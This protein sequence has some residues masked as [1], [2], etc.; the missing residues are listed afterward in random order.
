MVTGKFCNLC[1]QPTKGQ[2][3]V[4]RRLGSDIH[5][6]LVVCQRCEREARRCAI[7]RIPISPVVS[8]NGLCPTCDTQVPRCAACGQRI[9]GHY[10]RNESNG[11]YYCETCFNHRPHCGVCGGAVGRGGYQL[12]DGRFICAQC[13]DTA[14]Y[15][16]GKAAD[17]YEQVTGIMDQR[18]GMRL[19]MLPSLSLVD[20]NQM[21]ALLEQTEISDTDDPDRVFGLFLRRGRKRTIYVEYGLP[22]ILMIQIMA[23]EYAHAWQ[24]ENCPLLRDPFVREGF[25]E[26]AAYRV[27]VALGAVKKAALLEQRADL[28]GQGLQLMLALERQGGTAAVF[29]ACRSGETKGSQ[30]LP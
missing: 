13:H 3:N 10:I 19:N 18:L 30:R 5:K 9:Q 23:H 24:G 11:A 4:Y 14:V 16:A 25:S 2:Y 7:C 22:Q 27:L 29:Q 15:D 28:Y 20:R 1:G 26:W 21:L 8:V 12:H 17:L 6:G